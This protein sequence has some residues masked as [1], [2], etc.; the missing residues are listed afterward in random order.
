MRVDVVTH[1]GYARETL[2][3]LC[4]CNV[5]GRLGFGG[6]LRTARSIHLRGHGSLREFAYHRSARVVFPDCLATS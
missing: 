3:V 1:G 4:V 5:I 2:V 6:S